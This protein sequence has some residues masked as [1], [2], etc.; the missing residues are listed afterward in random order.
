[1]EAA[2]SARPMPSEVSSRP[3]ST[4]VAYPEVA[5]IWVSHSWP[6]AMAASPASS[7]YLMVNRVSSWRVSSVEVSTTT[8]VE[9]TRASPVARG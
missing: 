3:G 6:A 9:G 2:G 7:T 4:A 1:M 8:T 5:E